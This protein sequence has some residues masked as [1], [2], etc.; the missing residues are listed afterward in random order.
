MALLL[1]A[2]ENGQLDQICE[3]F[4]VRVLSAFGSVVHDSPVEPN[5][6][7]VGVSFRR[8]T[9]GQRVRDPRDRI[10]LWT[11][12]VELTGYEGIDLVV[13][14]VDNPVLRADALTGVPLYEFKAGEYAEAQIAAVGER[15]DT[16]HLRRRNLELMAQ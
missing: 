14:D 2:A 7:D 15:R 10:A 5:D 13:L 9:E 11:A 6:L 16:A 1:R 3:R 12:L 4:D 8:D